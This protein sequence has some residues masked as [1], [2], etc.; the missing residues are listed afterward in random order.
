MTTPSK[1]FEESDQKEID[2]LISRG[3]FA[4]EE[5]D[6]RKHGIIHIIK[7]RIVREIKGSSK[8]TMTGPGAA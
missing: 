4:L 1:P 5:C 8:D 2:A 7:S 3:V 6:P